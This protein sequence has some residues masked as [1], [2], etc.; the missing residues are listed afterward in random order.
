MYRLNQRFFPPHH[1]EEE[2]GHREVGALLHVPDGARMDHLPP[3]LHH[4]AGG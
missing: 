3:A 1:F 4:Q 2:D